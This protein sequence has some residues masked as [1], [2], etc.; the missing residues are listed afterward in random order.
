MAENRVKITSLSVF[1]CLSIL[2]IPKGTFA[3]TQMSPIHPQCFRNAAI[4]TLKQTAPDLTGAG[5]D[6]TVICRSISYTDGFPQNDYRPDVTHRCFSGKQFN[7]EDYN[8]TTAG[9][10]PH[11]TAIC[12]ILFGTDNNAVDPTLGEFSYAG[13]VPAARADICEFWYFLA[14]NVYTHLPPQSDIITASIGSQFESWWTR[15]LDALAEHYGLII[16]AGIGNG[17]E[18][19]DPPLYPGASAN[20]IGVGVVDSV[21]SNNLAVT[22][23]RFA[24]AYPE[25]SSFGPTMDKRCKPDIVAPGN[26][27]AAV[28]KQPNAYQP[29]GNWSSFSTPVVTGAAGL[30]V[31]KAKQ[32]PNL[33]SAVSPQGG[34][35]VIKALLLNSAVKLPYWHKGRLTTEDDHSRPL[36]F[37]QGAGML[38]AKAAYE[39]LIAGRKI[40]NEYST[41]GWDN[42][43]LD[44]NSPENSYYLSID[45]PDGKIISVTAAWNKHFSYM[46]PFEPVPEKDANLKLQLW[47]IDT[48][49]PQAGYL[50]DYSDSNTDNLE[51]IYCQADPNYTEYEVVIS[52]SGNQPT[53]NPPVQRYGLAWSTRDKKSGDDIL[54]YDLNTDGIVDKFDYTILFDNFIAAQESNE[55]YGVP[56]RFFR[57]WGAYLLGD[58]NG[59]GLINFED[60]ELLLKKADSKTDWL[61][62]N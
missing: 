13:V 17:L 33:S 24:L 30:L 18:V 56:K 39:N 55:A 37:I 44:A 58:I 2:I 16:V 32:D 22:L 54:W 12:S 40:P 19:W 3:S 57:V 49:N 36:D 52:Y 10:S 42:N 29:T 59:D 23:S 8:G 1:V 9:I 7:F 51:H 45:E 47:A 21:D 31:Q 46:Y 48:N 27:L 53:E 4:N 6:I 60:M 34:N 5:V 26:C 14:E 50:L 61:E 11:S 25:H 38:N 28:A 43:V 20:I 62:R 15:G 35:C 41:V